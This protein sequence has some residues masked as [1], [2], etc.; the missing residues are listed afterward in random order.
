ME[1]N[2][3]PQ[4]NNQ[5]N[6]YQANAYQQNMQPMNAYPQGSFQK[7]KIDV[8]G[9]II[10]IICLITSILAAVSVLMPIVKI[11]EE[12]MSVIEICTEMSEHIEDIDERIELFEEFSDDFDSTGYTIE[13][14]AVVI[15]IA[16][17][18]ILAAIGLITSIVLLTKLIRMKFNG[19]EVFSLNKLLKIEMIISVFSMFYI[20]YQDEY[21][22]WR[23]EEYGLGIG[24]KLPV[25]LCLCTMAVGII[26]EYVFN[27]LEKKYEN[28][29][30]VNGILAVV[31]MIFSSMVYIAFTFTRYV[32]INRYDSKSKGNVSQ[33]IGAVIDS[34]KDPDYYWD[35]DKMVIRMIWTCISLVVAIIIA[36]VA[37]ITMKKNMV[38]V[39]K[40][41]FGGVSSIITGTV[42]IVL[43]L[44]EYIMGKVL[45]ADEDVVGRGMKLEMGLAGYFYIIFGSLLIAV[46][47]AQ[48][49]V[50]NYFKNRA[51]VAANPYARMPQQGNMYQQN[52]MF[53]PNNMP[54]ANMYQQNTMPQQNNMQYTNGFAVQ[55]VMQSPVD[56]AYEKMNTFEI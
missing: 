10:T 32:S 30:V 44:V 11:D 27:L 15:S 40:G 25:I 45:F 35:S 53:Q 29:Y 36:I 31:A 6:G 37:S 51:K 8:K 24:W 22:L 3:N 5:V 16:M 7:K 56:N 54:Q 18:L 17:P 34:I 52:N 47:V 12:G 43:F 49:C 9:L 19:R 46:G 39:Q 4:M 26:L 21:S 48:I 55:N 33:F 50:K 2:F 14:V 1:N 42:A 20:Y 23:A 38:A 28:G 13:I 41:K